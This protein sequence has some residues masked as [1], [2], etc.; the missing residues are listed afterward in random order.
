[1]DVTLTYNHGLMYEMHTQGS[2][3][4]NYAGANVFQKKNMNF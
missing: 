2:G 3:G 1:M 4:T